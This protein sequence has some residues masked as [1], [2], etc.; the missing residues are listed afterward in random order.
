M[1]PNKK[2]IK[3]NETVEELFQMLLSLEV[4]N[5]MCLSQITD[6][7]KHFNFFADT[8]NQIYFMF[9]VISLISFVNIHFLFFYILDV[10]HI[11]K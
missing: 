8:T 3:C 5:H 6:F 11:R 9:M 2:P 1:S 10:Q 7:H 4:L